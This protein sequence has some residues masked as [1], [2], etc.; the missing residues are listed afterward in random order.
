MSEIHVKYQ[1]FGQVGVMGDGEHLSDNP[2]KGKVYLA[3]PSKRAGLA[4]YV[5]RKLKLDCYPWWEDFNCSPPPSDWRKYA[6]ADLYHIRQAELLVALWDPK[7]PSYGVMF[8]LGRSTHKS[9]VVVLGDRKSIEVPESFFLSA[10]E[11]MGRLVFVPRGVSSFVEHF[12]RIS[13]AVGTVIRDWREKL[14]WKGV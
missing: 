14:Y 5:A 13:E 1:N 6:D 3:G 2:K 11:F 12:D 4:S 8:E 9:V 7:S 10:S